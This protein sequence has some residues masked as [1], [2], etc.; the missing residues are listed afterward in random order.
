MRKLLA[1]VLLSL[2]IVSPVMAA[3]NSYLTLLAGVAQTITLGDAY[4]VAL[5]P[6]TNDLSVVTYYSVSGTQ[7]VRDVFLIPAGASKTFSADGVSQILLIST[8]GTVVDYNISRFKEFGPVIFPDLVTSIEAVTTDTDSLIVIADSLKTLLSA[9]SPVEVYDDQTIFTADITR[10]SWQFAGPQ[11]GIYV[12]GAVGLM[13][14]CTWD[15]LIGDTAG[16]VSVYQY[17][18]SDAGDTTTLMA[19]WQAD[20]LTIDGALYG[21]AAGKVT[22][23][24]TIPG[25]QGVATGFY[26]ARF[27]SWGDVTWR[28]AQAVMRAVYK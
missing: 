7:T 11:T 1:V 10:S 4:W 17:F 12:E 14:T 16:K 6:R 24:P 8:L 27:T 28:N 13:V 2:V 21:A 9:P 18:V 15:T 26:Y 25:N 22:W 20:T 19:G 23:F 3:T 5:A